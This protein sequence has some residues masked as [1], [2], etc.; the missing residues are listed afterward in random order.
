[1]NLFKF[2]KRQ[3]K[4]LSKL[5]HTH[6]IPGTFCYK[7]KKKRKLLKRPGIQGNTQ[8][9]QLTKDKVILTDIEKLEPDPSG[10]E[11]GEMES[12]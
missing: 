2:C 8:T 7:W 12:S 9:I 10:S 3:V 1:M 11:R 5:I 4:S 6:L